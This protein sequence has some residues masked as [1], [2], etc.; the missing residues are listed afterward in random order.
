MESFD[1]IADQFARDCREC[2][3]GPMPTLDGYAERYPQYAEQIR[4]LF[5]SILMMES[6]GS[7]NRQETSKELFLSSVPDQIGDY[8][9]VRELGRGGMGVVYEATQQ[10]LGRRVAI[11]LFLKHSS[12]PKHLQRFEREAR[13]AASLHHTNIVP[14][15]DVGSHG[16]FHY[17]VMQYIDGTSLENMIATDSARVQSGVTIR[18]RYNESTHPGSVNAELEPNPSDTSAESKPLQYHD[19]PFK[20]QTDAIANARP[21]RSR[22]HDTAQMLLQ[23]AKALSYAHSQNTL[24]RDIKPG[25]LILDRNGTVWVADFGLAKAFENDNVSQTGDIIGTLRYMAPEQF[26]GSPTARSDIY[27]LGLTAWELLTLSQP[28]GETGGARFGGKRGADQIELPS[29]TDPSVPRDLETIV[30]KACQAV[31]EDR[32]ATADQMAE[33][34]ENFLNDRPI[35]ARPPSALERLVKWGRRNPAVASLSALAALLLCLVAGAVAVGLW[36]TRSALDRESAQRIQTENEKIK[37]EKTLMISLDALDRVYQRFAPQRPSD[38]SLVTV[39]DGQ[40]QQVSI[41]APSV[42]SED[43]AAMLEDVLSFYDQLAA[44]ETENQQLKLQSA[45]A[46]RRVGAIHHQLSSFE[47]SLAAYEKSISQYEL[48]TESDSE[49]ALKIASIQ[50][51]IGDLYF[52]WNKLELSRESHA[53]ALATFETLLAN[54]PANQEFKLELARTLYLLEKRLP[55]SP[56]GP[57]PPRGR[58]RGGAPLAII[59]DL[60][61]RPPPKKDKEAAAGRGDHRRGERNFANLDLAIATLDE[62]SSSKYRSESQYLLALCHREKRELDKAVAI[63]ESL[64]EEFPKVLDYRFELAETYTRGNPRRIGKKDF[65]RAVSQIES[66]I[67]LTRTL[68]Q[69]HPNIPKFSQALSHNYHKL[70]ILLQR[71]A[72]FGK[73]KD[74][75]R[76]EQQKLVQQAETNF[77][78]AAEIQTELIAQFPNEDS[79]RMWLVI[80]SASLADLLAEENRFEEAINWLETQL[81]IIE[82]AAGNSARKS[83]VSDPLRKATSGLYERLAGSRQSIGDHEGAKAARREARKRHPKPGFRARQ[84]PNRSK[85]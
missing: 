32:Y 31:P 20:D 53:T 52:S 27:S 15:F 19:S 69:E 57:G 38:P 23:V 50:N 12:N 2:G 74:G 34:L 37:A 58:P 36:Q 85:S 66:G 10:S 21:D 47:K 16:G 67:R 49:A 70:G 78:N 33:D 30:M 1:D 82:G 5:P 7:T 4:Q 64:C 26:A 84:L 59:S 79:L 51:E 48:Y 44:Q 18:S 77:Q 11:K 29:K 61:M 76:S 25:N 72:S 40:G 63:L 43:T 24:H 55:P 8:R 68:K 62:L 14:V 46:S 71:M 28:F 54:E 80:M 9:I 83:L 17:Y 73:D 13:T 3:D 65:V 41:A 35:S 60:F 22:H 39:D 75:V 45:E 81:K 6:L 56:L 42:L